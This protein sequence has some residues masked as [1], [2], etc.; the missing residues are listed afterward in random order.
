MGG[1][2]NARGSNKK[3][4]RYK[5]VVETRKQVRK[6]RAVRSENCAAEIRN[7]EGVGTEIGTED[8]SWKNWALMAK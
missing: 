4:P 6:L 5:I 1:G 8:S 7:A 2:F 3:N